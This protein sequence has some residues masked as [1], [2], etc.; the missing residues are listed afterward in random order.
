MA[1]AQGLSLFSQ[2]S[3]SSL[4]TARFSQPNGSGHTCSPSQ[5]CKGSPDPARVRSRPPTALWGLGTLRRHPRVPKPSPGHHCQRSRS[6]EL[7][8]ASEHRPRWHGQGSAGGGYEH[9]LEEIILPVTLCE[10]PLP[11]KPA[12][13]PSE[14]AG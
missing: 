13:C 8:A 14:T 12:S 9:S 4:L 5:S 2:V 7:P 11:N 3:S 1:L 6:Q 10:P